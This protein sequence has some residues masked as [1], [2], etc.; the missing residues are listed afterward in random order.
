MLPDKLNP[1]SA[2]RR[3][4]RQAMTRLD[5]ALRTRSADKLSPAQHAR[6]EAAALCGLRHSEPLPRQPAQPAART[7]RTA[8]AAC[9]VSTAAMLM[10]ATWLF[11]SVYRPTA[12]PLPE[13]TAT[14]LFWDESE[15][16][17]QRLTQLAMLPEQ[18]LQ[19]EMSKLFDNVR[20]TAD[21]LADCIPT[22]PLANI[23]D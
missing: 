7:H 2:R 8:W 12:D 18:S 5:E 17:G 10:V 11:V 6:I 16:F 1:W 20:R 4:V 3:G 22:H 13:L 9:I 19:S 23:E 15:R 14:T 21:F